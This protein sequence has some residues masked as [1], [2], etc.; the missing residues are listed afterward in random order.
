MELETYFDFFSN[1]YYL[2]KLDA[3][4]GV[5]LIFII[6]MNLVMKLLILAKFIQQLTSLIILDQL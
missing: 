6:L 3:M 1:N 5:T 4:Y 2:K